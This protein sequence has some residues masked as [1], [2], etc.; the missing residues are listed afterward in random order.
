MNQDKIIMG[1]KTKIKELIA[2]F[3]GS[4]KVDVCLYYLN[5]C[6]GVN[7]KTYRVYSF[8]HG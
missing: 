2:L 5:A 8:K 6:Y 7:S 4:L 3:E 1:K